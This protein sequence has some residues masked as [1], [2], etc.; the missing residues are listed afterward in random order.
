[1]IYHIITALMIVAALLQVA[2]IC[3]FVRLIVLLNRKSR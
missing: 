3:W 1:M 2:A